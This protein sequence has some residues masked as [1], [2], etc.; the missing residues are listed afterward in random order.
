[1]L[2][3]FD[4]F[5]KKMLSLQILKNKRLVCVFTNGQ[6]FLFLMNYLEVYHEILLKYVRNCYKTKM[7]LLPTMHE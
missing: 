2:A 5:N 1:M 4:Y 6:K 3:R 7:F